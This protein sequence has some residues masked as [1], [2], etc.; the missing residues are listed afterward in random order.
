MNFDRIGRKIKN[1]VK[2]LFYIQVI[3][4]GILAL[5]LAISMAPVGILVGIVVFFIGSLFAWIFS[6]LLYGYGELIDKTCDMVELLQGK[7]SRADTLKKLLSD[8][9]ISKEE[10]NEVASN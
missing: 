4:Y 8:E 9:F 2:T 7:N 10:Y 6:W 5:F 1:L 3:I